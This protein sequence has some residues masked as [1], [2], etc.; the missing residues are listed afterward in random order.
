MLTPSLWGKSEEGTWLAT[1][2]PGDA[3]ELRG[4]PVRAVAAAAPP[5]QPGIAAEIRSCSVS[6]REVWVL[7]APRRQEI[8][9]NG[10]RVIQ[11]H[12]LRDRD[13]IWFPG[14]RTTLYWSTEQLV[15]IVP[16]PADLESVSCVRCKLPVEANQLA[17]QCS[18]CS[19][20]QH[21]DAAW[22]LECWT[23]G[24][25][26]GGCDTQPTDLGAGFRWRPEMA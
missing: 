9:V 24:P 6:G 3:F 20:W 5:T 25:L 22:E 12:I 8:W 1:P 11:M 23:Y 17:V 10:R 19:L 13:S 4:S 16:Y 2:L 7:L 15:R 21:Q 18:S 26:C 14:P